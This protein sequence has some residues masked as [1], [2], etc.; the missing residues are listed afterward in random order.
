[1]FVDT[2]GVLLA[3]TQT[4]DEAAIAVGVRTLEVVKQFATLADHLQ[5]TTTGVVI[6]GV[7]LEVAGQAIDA[8]GQQRDLDF[9]RTGVALCALEIGDDLRFLCGFESHVVYYSF[10]L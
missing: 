10:D 6:L 9:R 2:S 4:L 5:Q 1:M 8:S 7:C 3:Q